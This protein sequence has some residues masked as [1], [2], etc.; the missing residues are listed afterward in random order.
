M[1]HVSYSQIGQTLTE[2]CYFRL[3][4]PSI[5]ACITTIAPESIVDSSPREAA[6]TTTIWPDNLEPYSINEQAPRTVVALDDFFAISSTAASPTTAVPLQLTSSMATVPDLITGI[7]TATPASLGQSLVH[8]GATSVSSL[9]INQAV[10]TATTEA[11]GLA[12][13]ASSPAAKE[14]SKASHL[15]V[16]TCSLYIN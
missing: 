11:D 14:N 15:L 13:P 16:T 4:E 2:T 9:L 1:A 6:V 8:L 5:L 10:P 7:L 3:D 12:K